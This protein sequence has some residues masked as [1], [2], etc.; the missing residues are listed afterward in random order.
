MKQVLTVLGVA[1]ALSLGACG[2]EASSAAARADELPDFGNKGACLAPVDAS[3]ATTSVEVGAACPGCTIDNPD[4]VLNPDL[5]D[6]AALY[7]FLAA[8][9]VGGAAD[10]SLSVNLGQVLDPSV[11]PQPEEDLAEGEEAPLLFAPE[12][13]GFTV[14]FPDVAAVSAGVLPDLTVETLLNGEVVDTTFYGFGFFDS[15]AVASFLQDI[16]NAEV[17]LPVAA[18]A[19]YDAIRL[20]LTGIVANLSLN[21]NAHAACTFGVGGSISGDF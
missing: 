6:A 14:S 2:D 5:A 18:T 4:G 13:P 21:L 20:S 1:S 7:A 10:L 12:A 9:P 11:V 3:F 15:L 16:N 8:L 19:P 17:Y